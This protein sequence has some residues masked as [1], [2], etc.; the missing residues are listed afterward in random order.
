MSMELPAFNISPLLPTAQDLSNMREVKVLDIFT[1]STKNF[2]PE[3]LFSIEIFGKVGDETRNRLFAYIDLRTS[4]FHPTIFNSIIGLKS[5]YGEIMSGKAYAVF[6]KK[7]KDFVKS[8]ATDGR[9]GFSFFVE[10]FQELEFEKRPSAQRE[11]SI[12]LV[13]K[14][15]DKA[16]ITKTLVM[17]AGLRDYVI[18][19][20][21]KP[22]EDE[23]NKL[24]RKIMSIAGTM[25]NVNLSLNSSFLDASRYNLQMAQMEVY[26]YIVSLM[27]GKKKLILG[28]FASRKVMDS[29]RNVITA[30]IPEV[31]E[32]GDPKSVSS[33]D[34]IVGM[35][36]FMRA[37]MPL[38]VKAVRDNYSK[39]IFNGPNS[40]AVLVNAKTLKKEYVQLDPEYYDTWMTYDGIEKICARFKEEQIRH[41]VLKANGYYL[42]L[43][44]NDGKYFKFIQDIDEVP[45]QFDKTKVTPITLAQLLYIAIY[46]IAKRTPAFVTRYPVTG[47]GSIYP[48]WTYLRS[49]VKSVSLR[50][51]DDAWQPIQSHLANE[52]PITGLGFYNSMSPSNSHLKKLGADFDGDTMSYTALWGEESIQEIENLLRSRNYYVGL[53][54]NMA[55]SMSDDTINLMLSSM[56]S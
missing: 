13:E 31:K 34:T 14:Y 32:L 24:Y 39:K 4:I 15:K 49:T 3:G 35:Y 45:E 8:T 1:A 56:T 20:T 38:T 12:K 19:D 48:S 42:G 44:F 11:F 9:T 5:L 50:E 2:H 40:P 6:D 22:S 21:G 52:F 43:L 30:G 53:D 41:E 36:Q 46:K 18:D 47:L 17:P 55:F 29:T 10:H 26:D 16:L 54:G 25:Q 7:T 37:V 28:R 33:N 51:L 23:I 27:E